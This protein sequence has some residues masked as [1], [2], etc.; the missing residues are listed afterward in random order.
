ML[1]SLASM[2]PEELLA[3]H[4][5]DRPL[6]REQ[7]WACGGCS[8]ESFERISAV[9]AGTSTP[10]LN[11]TSKQVAHCYR[12]AAECRELAER[13]ESE[14]QLYLERE[15][16]WLTLARSFEFS[17]R[18]GRAIH[19]FSGRPGRA[20]NG[21]RR[22]KRR[23]RLATQ[24]ISPAP[25]C[26]ACGVEMGLHVFLPTF[27]EVQKTYEDAFFICPNCGHLSDYLAAL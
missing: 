5:A 13:H 3:H 23:N 6:E 7:A 15:Q 8:C 2:T 21:T 22:Q 24:C 25:K 19:E 1:Q 26:P 11:N 16:A 20:T 10:M 14:R 27:V 4:L 9:A 12:R 18:V 17:E